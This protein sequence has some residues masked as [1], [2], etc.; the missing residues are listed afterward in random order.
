M[1]KN[2]LLTFT[3]LVLGCGDNTVPASD[4]HSDAR[5]RSQTGTQRAKSQSATRTNENGAAVVVPDDVVYTV[6]DEEVVPEEKRSLDIRLNRKVSEDVLRAIALELKNS[7]SEPYNRTFM[8]YYLPDSMVDAG[9]WATTHF[10]PDL[11]VRILGMTAESEAVLRSE[12]EPAEDGR[13]E[14]GRWM[15]NSPFVEKR[16]VIF[17]QNGKFFMETTYKDGSSKID[18]LVEQDSKR[19]R[20]FAEARGSQFDEHWVI[21]SAGNLALRDEEGTYATAK[22]ID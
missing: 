9:Y 11:E 1:R 12:P 6:I 8:G 16:L 3:I 7:E 13:A 17:R 4:E 14:I 2:A 18:E 10:N 20:R 5:Q 19:G 22:K 21:N 15:D